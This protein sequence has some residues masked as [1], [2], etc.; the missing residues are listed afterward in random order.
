MDSTFFEQ[1]K[2]SSKRMILT[3]VVGLVALTAI[4]GV[5]Y[6][7]SSP[8][9]FMLSADSTNESYFQLHLEKY[10]KSYSEEEYQSRLR[11]FNDNMGYIRKVNSFGRSWYLRPNQFTDLS[12]EE[13]RAKYLPN[14]MM[15]ETSPSSEVE[16]NLSYP[17][18]IDWT[19]QGVVTPVKNQGQ[20]GSCWAFSTTGAV[21]SAWKLAGHTLISLSEQQ[22]VDCA[23]SNY[24]CNGGWPTVAMQYI[25]NNKGIALESSYPYTAR[26]G[27]CNTASASKI[28]ATI[29][30]Y[31]TVTAGS[32]SA[33]ATAVAQQPVSVLVDA[34]G[35]DWQS[36]G[37]GVVTDAGCGTSLD[38]AVLA[39]GYNM[40]NSPP[41]WKIKNSWGTSW[42]E[43]GYIRLGVVNGNGI[44]GVQMNSCYPVV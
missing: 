15:P 22:L 40:G 26:T 24:G 34:G 39:V 6:S 17:T 20:C 25:I 42:G 13:F 21:E 37:G 43:S 38:H 9:T 10:G 32:V 2:V 8:A 14:K 7:S 30:G 29:S 31:K 3:S 11:I 23:K 41:F 27:S 44:C 33:L 1:R 19:T 16:E 36:Y 5:Y 35:A 12:N 4:L 18:S 28:A